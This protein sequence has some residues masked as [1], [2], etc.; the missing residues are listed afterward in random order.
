MY[1]HLNAV[2]KWRLAAG[3]VGAATA[4]SARY[5]TVCEQI[6]D[7]IIT[8]YVESFSCSE[9][10]CASCERISM[11]KLS[12]TNSNDWSWNS[13]FFFASHSSNTLFLW[14]RCF[15]IDGIGYGYIIDITVF[16]R[17]S[18]PRCH[19]STVADNLCV[20]HK[21]LRLFYLYAWKTKWAIG[22]E[23]TR[24]RRRWHLP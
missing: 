2:G 1:E 19:A 16:G 6:D 10:V 7:D 3:A 14:I 15:C 13:I 17:M 9:C 20:S 18:V 22:A 11:G 23:N 5:M 8:L 21:I 12:G 4:L 24:A